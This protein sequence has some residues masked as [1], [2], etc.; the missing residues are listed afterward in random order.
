MKKIGFSGM[1]GCGKTTLLNE[2]KKV[3]SLKSK[4]ELTPKSDHTNLF[5]EDKKLSFES[6]FFNISQCINKENIVND[7]SS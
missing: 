1:S 7:N 3:L 4:T 5:D 2:V 6:Q